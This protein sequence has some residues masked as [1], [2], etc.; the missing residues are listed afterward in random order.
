MK[1]TPASGKRAY[2]AY[3]GVALFVDGSQH[4]AAITPRYVTAWNDLGKVEFDMVDFATGRSLTG[5][6]FKLDW[7]RNAYRA[8]VAFIDILYKADRD[9]SSGLFHQSIFLSVFFSN[10][11]GLFQKIDI[12]FR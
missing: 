8:T 3:R 5:M 1:V 6:Q 12:F 2:R 10:L 9:L 7:P 4:P 11:S